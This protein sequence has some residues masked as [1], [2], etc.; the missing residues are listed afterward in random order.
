[1]KRIF[2]VI[3]AMIVT[4]M[5]TGSLRYCAVQRNRPVDQPGSKWRSEDGSIYFE[6]GDWSSESLAGIGKMKIGEEETLD[7]YVATGLGS[8][9]VIYPLEN[10][11]PEGVV[12]L[13]YIEYWIGDFHRK[14]RFTAT[15]KKTT[16]F[17]VGEKVKFYRVDDE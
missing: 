10:V 3:M 5:L 15:V 7:I 4:V 6:V 17:S 9:I 8:D 1:M 13:P 12:K 16:Y 14:D 11:T 2:L